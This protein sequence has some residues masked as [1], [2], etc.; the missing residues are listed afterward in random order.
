[1]S[2][3]L[4]HDDRGLAGVPEMGEDRCPGKSDAA[5]ASG[6]MD[7]TG[8][9][10]DELVM[11]T[12][13][14]LEYQALGRSGPP[15]SSRGGCVLRV[16]SSDAVCADGR[17]FCAR[18]VIVVICI[19]RRPAAWRRAGRAAVPPTAAMRRARRDARATGGVSAGSGCAV[20]RGSVR[21]LVSPQ[22]GG[23]SRKKP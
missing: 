19:A 15:H 20:G 23:G 22:P 10:P 18:P 7:M 2:R 16:G 1:M 14:C 8:T 13:L 6:S 4:V 11:G 12:A 21:R 17:W 9:A 3:V 5:P